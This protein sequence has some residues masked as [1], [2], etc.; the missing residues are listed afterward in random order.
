MCQTVSGVN[1]SK[2]STLAGSEYEMYIH[3]HFEDYRR[4]RVLV[5]EC[6]PGRSPVFVKD[7]NTERFYV[8]SSAA[9]REL[10]PSETQTYIDQ[11]FK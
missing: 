10:L 8:R 1:A 6:S 7:G 4:H 9:T 5:V 3:S 2:Y 11:R